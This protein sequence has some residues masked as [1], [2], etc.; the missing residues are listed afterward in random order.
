MKPISPV[1]SA[2]KGK[3]K[4]TNCVVTKRLDAHHR[5]TVALGTNLDT[6]NLAVPDESQRYLRR[7]TA[8]VLPTAMSWISLQLVPQHLSEKDTTNSLRHDSVDVLVDVIELIHNGNIGHEKE[9]VD[10]DTT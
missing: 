4:V 10:K 6:L 7:R 9:R 3:E 5:H 2:H 8:T 1:N